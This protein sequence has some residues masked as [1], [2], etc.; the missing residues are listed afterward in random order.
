MIQAV[1]NRSHVLRS[2]YAS[3]ASS[4]SSGNVSIIIDE[5]GCIKFVDGSKEIILSVR[6]MTLND[7][8]ISNL[9]FLSKYLRIGYD[10]IYMND[11]RDWKCI[12]RLVAVGEQQS[13]HYG[14]ENE[15]Q[16]MT[17]QYYWNDIKRIEN[18]IETHTHHEY[19]S[20]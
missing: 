14:I 19:P 2:S 20:I 18:K 10:G 16:L 6:N 7:L 12:Q 15:V 1:M 8:D 5:F 17:A 4:L 3:S 11:D 9:R 13:T